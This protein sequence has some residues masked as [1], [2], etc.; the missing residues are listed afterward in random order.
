MNAELPLVSTADRWS[1][2]LL[3]T[4]VGDALGLPAEGLSRRRA[5]RLL[6]RPWRHRLL[7]PFGL[8]SDDTEHTLLVAQ[9]LIRHPDD[10]ERFRRRLA[11]GLRWWLLA[12]PAGVGLATGRSILKLWLGIPPDRAGVWS[13]GNGAAMRAAPMGVL[14]Q[15]D[16]QRRMAYVRA[17]S[18]ITHRDP[19]AE[20]G[21]QAVAAVC[22]W[23]LHRGGAAPLS[24]DALA[25]L[26]RT[27]G[28]DSEWR[29]RVTGLC[30]ALAAGQSVAEYAAALGLERGV[31]GY[32]YH[33][34]P[35][36]LF[37]WHRHYGDFAATLTA[38]LDCGGDTD[39]VGAIAGALAGAVVGEA[40]IPRPWLEG[41]RDWPRSVPLLRRVAERL[42]QVAAD[43]RPR[44]PLRYCLAAV[45][46]RNLLFLALVL[47][48]GLRRLLPPY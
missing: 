19:R 46:V 37:A 12:L 45:P 2:V 7:G 18:R 33:T 30:A 27:C 16:P 22:A 17:S 24:P 11:R 3:G 1:G 14:F 43:G 8:V 25:D 21:A 38:V 15:T 9:A 23:C 35:V 4:A 31:G 20:T 44:P 47:G 34:V 26:L 48:H 5:R 10:L 39:T 28:D 13:A 41:L 36:A 32:V 6:A 42:A 29:E 40:G